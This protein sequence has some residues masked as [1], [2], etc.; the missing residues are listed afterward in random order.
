MTTPAPPTTS[1]LATAPPWI[2]VVAQPGVPGGAYDSAVYDAATYGA[3]G[4]AAA[5]PA[6]AGAAYGAALATRGSAVAG[7]PRVL[8]GA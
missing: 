3:L 8:P 4:Q 6:A 7:P 5:T 2:P 1:G